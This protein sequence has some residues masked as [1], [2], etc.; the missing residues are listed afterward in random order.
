[1]LLP[2]F[3]VFL[4]SSSIVLSRICR[5]EELIDDQGLAPMP[6]VFLHGNPHISNFSKVFTCSF[7]Y[8]YELLK[9]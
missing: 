2:T 7:D 1:M 5:F 3:R 8:E 9:H 6:V 4:I